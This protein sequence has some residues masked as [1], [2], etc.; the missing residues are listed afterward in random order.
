MNKKS[1]LIIHDK[2]GVIK[3]K[4]SFGKDPCLLRDR[5]HYVK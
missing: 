4:D 3:D 2:H 1:E 5:R